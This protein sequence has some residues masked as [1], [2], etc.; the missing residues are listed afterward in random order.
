MN[1]IFFFKLKGRIFLGGLEDDQIIF[2]HVIDTEPD[3]VW[4]MKAHSAS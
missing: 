1:L 2:H 3:P 4:P